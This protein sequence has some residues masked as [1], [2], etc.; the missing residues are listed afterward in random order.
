MIDIRRA[1]DRT[2][3]YGPG[4]TTRH[5]FSSGAYY[6]PANTHFGRLVA[7]DVHA[8][9]P[10]A[11]FDTHPHRELEIVSWVLS[12]TLLHED[13]T[14][15][16]HTV[17]HGTAQHLSAGDGVEH[18]ERNGGDDELRFVQMWLLGEAGTPSYRV[19]A[20]PLR[21]DDARFEAVRGDAQVTTAPFV[22]VFVASGHARLGAIAL[23]AGD[24]VRISDTA[25]TFTG[26]ADLLTW[27][28]S[29]APQR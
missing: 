28:M 25:A 27:T 18:A 1:V 14:G 3:T 13:S 15:R 21:L 11:G 23:G 6:D 7:H 17:R 20:P 8:L 19:Q 16:R 22:H 5:G 12:G 29:A 10:G 26:T 2:V 4:I 9:R 24:E